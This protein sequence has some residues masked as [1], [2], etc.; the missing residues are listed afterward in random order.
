[1]P[2]AD[3]TDARRERG[4]RVDLFLG[5]SVR[6]SKEQDIAGSNL[7]GRRK[8]ELRPPAQIGVHVVKILADVRLGCHLN[9][10]GLRVREQDACQ[11]PS[12][13]S[14]TTDDRGFDHQIPTQTE[15]R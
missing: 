3:P 1:M 9:E 15:G 8:L 12:R 14:R 7:I 4:K 6:E 5:L 2:K 11:L 10:F 13:V